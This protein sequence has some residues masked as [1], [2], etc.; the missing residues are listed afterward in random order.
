MYWG[1]TKPG[2]KLRPIQTD[3]R[4]AVDYDG[5]HISYLYGIVIGQLCKKDIKLIFIKMFNYKGAFINYDLGGS[6]N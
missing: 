2:S 6:A 1:K 4:V 3:E 5:M